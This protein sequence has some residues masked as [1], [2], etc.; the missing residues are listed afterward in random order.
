MTPARTLR[1]AFQAT[2]PRPL[3]SHDPYF[4]DLSQARGSHATHH[5]K[6]MIENCASDRWSAIAFTGHRGSGKS[7]ELH[8]L[9]QSLRG[10]CF[11]LYLDVNEFLDASDVSYT[12]LFLLL[13]RR[14][15]DELR[16]QNVHLKADL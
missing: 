4:V 15:L 2:D 5:M 3:E 6:R 14:L 11:T 9:E 7:T 8:Q 1:E 12:D 16:A 13:S 10:S